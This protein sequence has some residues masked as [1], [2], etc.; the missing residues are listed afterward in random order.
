M[1]SPLCDGRVP[2]SS[3]MLHRIENGQQLAHRGDQRDLGCFAG[4][5]Q[6][7]VELPDDRIPARRH[8]GG[9]LQR[10]A[11]R[12]PAAPDSPLAT[13]SPTVPIEGS[14][15]YQS[16]NLFAIQQTQLRQLG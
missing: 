7:L 8:Q 12:C 1:S 11:N 14:H 4:S 5:P 9:H 16:R 2:V 15:A 6:S 13:Q 10:G 3:L